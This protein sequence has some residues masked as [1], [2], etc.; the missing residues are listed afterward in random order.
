MR[1]RSK[2]SHAAPLTPRSI[3]LFIP[4]SAACIGGSVAGKNIDWQHIDNQ[5]ASIF[6]DVA[7]ITGHELVAPGIPVH[8]YIYDCKTGKINHVTSGVT[9]M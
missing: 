7:R 3:Y 6:L 1:I 8:G 9:R 5:E 2:K 4:T